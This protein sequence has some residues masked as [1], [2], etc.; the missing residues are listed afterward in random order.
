[1]TEQHFEVRPAH[2]EDADRLIE[3]RSYYV[4]SLYQNIL[5]KDMLAEWCRYEAPIIGEW[6][7]QGRYHIDV[8]VINDRIMGYIVYG[9]S[10]E[11][12][13]GMIVEAR[14]EY[15]GAAEGRHILIRH[16]LDVFRQD[17]F[18]TVKTWLQHDNFRIRFLFESLGF[19]RDGTQ[20]INTALTEEYAYDGYAYQFRR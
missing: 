7:A 1:M 6:L 14:A 5:D 18:H 17:G 10:G 12:D 8:L 9:A 2:Q 13:M 15:P 11:P 19:Y 16:A 4:S 20:K 3:L